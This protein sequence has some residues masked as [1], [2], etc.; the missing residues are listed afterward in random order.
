MLWKTK[1]SLS[2]NSVRT[3]CSI[4]CQM[5]T[6]RFHWRIA[7]AHNAMHCTDIFHWLRVLF[8]SHPKRYQFN[9]ASL[10]IK[11]KWHTNIHF[12]TFKIQLYV[13]KH[14]KH[15]SPVIN[16]LLCTLTYWNRMM[17]HRLMEFCKKQ[18]KLNKSYLILLIVILHIYHKG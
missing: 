1:C 7:T 14:L 18:S 12:L 6:I 11:K 15:A 4:S 10:N 16:T 2:P 3:R 5:I 9:F 8:Q 13:N 17:I